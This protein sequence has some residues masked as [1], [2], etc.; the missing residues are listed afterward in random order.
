M[1]KDY[2]IEKI[3]SYLINTY[4]DYVLFISQIDNEEN[5]II[6]KKDCI[7]FLI[8]TENISYEHNQEIMKHIRQNINDCK[9]NVIFTSKKETMN[10]NCL[11]N[12]A[13]Q[14]LFFAQ[15]GISKIFYHNPSFTY[16]ID[17]NMIKNIS[18]NLCLT[19]L[20]KI[21]SLVSDFDNLVDKKNGQYNLLNLVYCTAKEYFIIKGIFPQN[22]NQCFKIL[23]EVSSINLNFDIE[24]VLRKGM[25]QSED[26]EKLKIYSFKVAEFLLE[27]LNE[28]N[29][30]QT[31]SQDIRV[32]AND[33]T[34]K[35]RAG[36]LIEFNDKYLFV[37][38][39]LGS[40]WCVPGGHLEWFENS[41]NAV[42]REV[43][44]ETGMPV[45]IKNLFLLHENFYLNVKNQR[46][47]ELCFYY[48]LKPKDE[49]KIIKD[50]IKE[51]FDKD[52]KDVL[53][54]KWFTK[55]EIKKLE[56]KPAII[57]EIIMNNKINQMNHE[58]KK[59]FD[60]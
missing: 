1:N 31:T 2:I 45:E 11:N 25:K 20:S 23:S 50:Q 34:Y 26:F 39:G 3:T 16:F 4:K 12:R 42:I 30:V 32:K 58:I 27:R 54:F 35:V 24:M 59:N 19:K 28:R 44:E 21:I 55:D 49:Q 51:E 43:E 8:I 9:I 6:S 22:I 10:Y 48:L 53:E 14:G 13:M 33:V 15:K 57:K 17:E 47:H 46:F 36:G 37:K 38:M 41:E 40:Y 18:S 52:K 5:D 7:E 29:Y 60:D 56:I